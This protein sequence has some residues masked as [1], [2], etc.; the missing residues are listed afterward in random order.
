M[1][2]VDDPPVLRLFESGEF[3]T[4]LNLTEKSLKLIFLDSLISQ[5]LDFSGNGDLNYYILACFAGTD[6]RIIGSY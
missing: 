1:R 6:N 2:S 4:V 3:D 5:F